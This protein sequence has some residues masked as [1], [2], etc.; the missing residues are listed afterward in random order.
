[1]QF[2]AQTTVESLNLVHHKILTHLYRLPLSQLASDGF[3]DEY[4]DTSTGKHSHDDP[5][6]S[7]IKVEKPFFTS[8]Q[9]RHEENIGKYDFGQQ[10]T[11][12]P[13]V[14]SYLSRADTSG[15]HSRC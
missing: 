13:S 4:A 2:Q 15:Q 1:M 10:F 3:P 6:H 11:R 7:D 5:K 12:N 14:K 8:M 9:R